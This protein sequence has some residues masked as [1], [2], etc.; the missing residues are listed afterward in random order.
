M[1][2]TLDFLQW[3]QLSKRQNTYRSAGCVIRNQEAEERCNR[4]FN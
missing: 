1:L 3:L 2:E 4:C